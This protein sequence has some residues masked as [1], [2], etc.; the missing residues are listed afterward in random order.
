MGEYVLRY[1]HLS[2]NFWT[3]REIVTSAY[4][5]AY[6]VLTKLHSDIFFISKNLRFSGTE[7][8]GCLARHDRIAQL[9]AQGFD[10]HRLIPV[11]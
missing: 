3:C 6:D 9:S 5:I 4:A 1:H 2:K 7:T 10:A 11:G 8:A